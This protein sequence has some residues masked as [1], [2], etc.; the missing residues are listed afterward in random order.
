MRKCIGNEVVQGQNAIIRFAL[1][2]T[3]FGHQQPVPVYTSVMVC[4]Q[5]NM[6]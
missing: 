3:D 5:E 6:K 2:K 1:V 4:C